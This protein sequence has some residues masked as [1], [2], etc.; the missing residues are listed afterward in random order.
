MTPEI[1]KEITPEILKEIDKFLESYY[2]VGKETGNKLYQTFGDEKKKT[3]VRNLEN[4]IYSTTRFSEIK[5]FIKNQMGKSKK[6]EGWLKLIDR[7][8]ALGEY[9]LERLD[10][11]E[12]KA[13]EIGGGGDALM[14]ETKLRLARGWIRQS[15]SHY[16]FRLVG[17]KE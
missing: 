12:R 16:T 4:I 3:Q 5:N 6:G 8:K 1:L 10:E 14:L 7:N 9:L 15:A 13:S 11:L 2:E 17:G